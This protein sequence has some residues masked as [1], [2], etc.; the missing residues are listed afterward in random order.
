MSYPIEP[1]E[2]FCPT[3][4]TRVVSKGLAFDLDRHPCPMGCKKEEEAS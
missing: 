4:G 2:H 1:A 3:C